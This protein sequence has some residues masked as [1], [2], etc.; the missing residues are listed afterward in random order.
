MTPAELTDRLAITLVEYPAD[1]WGWLDGPV[2]HVQATWKDVCATDEAGIVLEL[3]GRGLTHE[4]AIADFQA[5][6]DHAITEH[7]NRLRLAE[8]LNNPTTVEEITL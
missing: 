6:V 4:E 2:F 8:I 7:E 1:P 5:S 3:F